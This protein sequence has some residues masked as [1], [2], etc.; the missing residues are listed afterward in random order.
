[1]CA[2]MSNT[3]CMSELDHWLTRLIQTE[4]D[5]QETKDTVFH[6][7]EVPEMPIADY[8]ERIATYSELEVSEFIICVL[9]FKR[10]KKSHPHF[11]CSHHSMHRTILTLLL[12]ATKMHRD[13][14][15][16]NKFYARLGE[17]LPSELARLERCIL[18]LLDCRL[19]VSV[20]EYTSEAK[21]W[22]A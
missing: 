4:R 15:F 20:D 17:V 8:I 16:S 7:V 6:G 13:R 3:A 9:Y 10:I 5:K 1:M 18:Q 2:N 19:F 12:V 21:H 14:P 11:P 22:G